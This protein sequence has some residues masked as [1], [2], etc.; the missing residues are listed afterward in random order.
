[1]DAV[2]EKIFCDYFFDEH[3]MAIGIIVA[4]LDCGCALIG[5]F[6]DQG[7][8]CTPL[9]NLVPTPVKNDTIPVCLTCLMDG[10]SNSDRIIKGYLIFKNKA[11]T[12]GQIDVIKKK[13]FGS[14]R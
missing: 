9:C 2:T 5:G 3:P 11:L 10:G 13:A 14:D 4:E 8:P 7:D 6:T 12:Q 1:M